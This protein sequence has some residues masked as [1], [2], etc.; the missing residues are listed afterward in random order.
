M[1]AVKQSVVLNAKVNFA[2]TNSLVCVC[3]SPFSLSLFPFLSLYLLFPFEGCGALSS[4][5]FIF[6]YFWNLMESGLWE[7][8]TLEIIRTISSFTGTITN[9]GSKHL[10]GTMIFFCAMAT[11]LEEL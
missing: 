8:S 10:K 4:F 9:Q 1:A 7:H 11:E 5:I 6:C 3:T 2:A